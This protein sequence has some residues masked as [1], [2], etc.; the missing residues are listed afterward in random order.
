MIPSPPAEGSDTLPLRAGP[1][2]LRFD[3]RT[4]YLRYVYFG[5]TEVVRAIY[6]AVRD[7]NWDTV[8]P[9]I[10]NLRVEQRPRSFQLTFDAACRQG[11]VAFSWRGELRGTAMAEITYTF[12]GRAERTFRKNRIGLCVLHPSRSLAGKPCV[13]THTDGTTT[14]SR[15]PQLIAPHQPFLALRALRYRLGANVEAEILLEG[16]TF[17]MEDQRNW[18]DGSFKIYGTPLALP[19]PVE[20][21]AGTEVRQQVQLRLLDGWSEP[22]PV[23]ERPLELRQLPLPRPLR[24]PALGFGLASHGGPLTARE[25]AL[26]QALAPHHLRVDLR[27]GDAAY[28]SVL[29]RATEQAQALNTS[30]LAV[31]H[32]SGA[33]EAQLRHLAKDLDRLQPPIW[34]WL[35]LHEQEKSA[36][37]HWV[38]LARDLL[39]KPYAGCLFG[40]G[41]NA[42]FAELNR[43]RPEPGRADFVAYSL[44]PQVHGSDDDTLAEALEAVPDQVH[45]ARQFAGP[46]QVVVSPI[47][48]RPRFNPNRTEPESGQAAGTLPDSV[49]PRQRSLFAAVWTLGV[50]AGLAEAEAA[51]ATFFETTG[52]QGLLETETGP[53]RPDQF[54]AAPG[55]LFPVYHLFAALNAW[56]GATVEIYEASVPLTV[57]SL[58]LSSPH[59]RCL[60]LGNLTRRRQTVRLPIQAGAEA[61]VQALTDSTLPQAQQLAHGFLDLPGQPLPG[62]HLTL[63]PHALVCVRMVAKEPSS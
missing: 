19:F 45:T 4:G 13:V 28:G 40:T 47:T 30:L 17:E 59:G 37:P 52:W 1:L 33:A 55:E 15:F 63:A 22:S 39:G 43:G 27:L 61:V 14:A 44:N 36:S 31:V 26:L 20:I 42:Y 53:P 16:E 62:P 54:P 25:R 51:A 29:A 38:Q 35:V 49:D 60:L 7:P 58:G 8:P 48:L 2:T 3:P 18:C 12:T 11:P 9:A 32:L 50:V 5:T 46:S 57:T 21:P 10:A 6:A 24:C 34:A 41:T 56:P 23:E